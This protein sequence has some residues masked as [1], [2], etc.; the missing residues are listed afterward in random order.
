MGRQAGMWAS[1]Q[2]GRQV[3]GRAGRQAGGRE[4]EVWLVG[5]CGVWRLGVKGQAEDSRGGG[6][7]VRQL[8]GTSVG[9]WASE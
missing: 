2:V 8:A 6:W 1:R 5:G 7:L 9:W 3:A 4:G